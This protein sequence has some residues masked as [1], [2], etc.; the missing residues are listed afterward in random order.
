MDALEP[1]DDSSN[2][3]SR[4][5]IFRTVRKRLDPIDDPRA[6][7]QKRAA[8]QARKRRDTSNEYPIGLLR[9]NGRPTVL[10]SRDGTVAFAISLTASGVVVEKRHCP[11]RGLRISHLMIFESRSIFDR[12]CDLEP[13]RFDEPLLCDMLRRRGHELFATC[14]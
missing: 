7:G 9:S 6:L 12:W 11:I 10:A 1:N 3:P 13:T 4:G 14:G 8:L 2:G 5:P